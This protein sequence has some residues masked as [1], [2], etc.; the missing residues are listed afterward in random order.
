MSV[1]VHRYFEQS[2]NFSF[3]DQICRSSLS[4]ASNIAEG[5]EKESRKERIRF[6]EIAR[7]SL[8]ELMTQVY[9]GIEIG[10]IEKSAG[11]QWIKEIEELSRMLM[12]LKNRYGKELNAP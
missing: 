9:I 6:L 2:K 8:A 11:F 3:K 4:V 12:G 5:V 10:Y 1:D 7:G